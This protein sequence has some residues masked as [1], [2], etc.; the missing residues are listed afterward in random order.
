M[1]QVWAARDELLH[2]DVAVKEMHPPPGMRPTD[3]DAQCERTMRE[4]RATARLEHPNV[5][6]IMD[7]VVDRGLP[8]IVMELVPSRS[9]HEVI[10]REGPM[11]PERVARIGLDV[12]AALRA[13]HRQRLLHRD[14]K[15]ANV[16]LAEDGRTVLVDFGLV[17]IAG[18]SSMTATGVVLGSPS[19]LAPELALDSEATPASDLWS[20]GATLYA[21]VEGSP[22]YL[23]STPTATLAALAT[24][25]P[26][27]PKRAG[28][29]G[30]VLHGL[31]NRDPE[32]RIDA[33]TAERLLRIA[34]GDQD[35]PARRSAL[36]DDGVWDSGTHAAPRRR[37]RTLLWVA[38]VVVLLGSAVLLD[39][40]V[41]PHRDETTTATPSDTPLAV[42]PSGGV[43]EPA[44]GVIEVP[45]TPSVAPS[46]PAPTLRATTTPRPKRSPAV[47]DTRTQPTPGSGGTGSTSESGRRIIIVSLVSRANNR[48]VTADDAGASP[49]LAFPEAVGP[50]ETWYEVNLGGGDIALRS[51][52][53]KKYVTADSAGAEPLIATEASVGTSET[54]RLIRNTD[55]TVSFLARAN[56]KYVTAA[57]G[58]SEPLINNAD[59]IGS[60][61]KF[62]RIVH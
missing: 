4:A 22:P 10:R 44:E 6:R 39:P 19:Y 62:E 55:G 33:V 52:V 21:A 49:L 29:L 36:T 8:C 16:L 41:L 34:A 54:F 35:V 56:G 12:L 40:P 45:E 43:L 28:A 60:G 30:D 14:V 61:Q 5:V 18:D 32:Q 53:N 50:W 24:E 17:W 13:A 26:R 46:Q 37:G 58:G 20:L 11:A 3:V 9:L 2:R 25:L 48:Y 31:L 47:N 57:E 38:G 23:K 42:D 59:A 15:P 1:G 7:V 51:D 27:R